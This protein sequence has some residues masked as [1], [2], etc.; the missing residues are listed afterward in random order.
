MIESEAFP[1]LF[2][3]VVNKGFTEVVK[4]VVKDWIEVVA[5]PILPAS[6]EMFEESCVLSPMTFSTGVTYLIIYYI[7]STS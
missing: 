6:F 5:V 1:M 3:T 2:L 4:K 7:E